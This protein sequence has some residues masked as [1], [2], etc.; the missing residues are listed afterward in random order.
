MSRKG[1]RRCNCASGSDAPWSEHLRL[2]A[3]ELGVDLERAR[4][5]LRS[6]VLAGTPTT[7]EACLA[8]GIDP[9]TGLPLEVGLG[10]PDE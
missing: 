7:W 1:S 10:G 4:V 2:L 3:D 9:E 6:D 5:R 8:M